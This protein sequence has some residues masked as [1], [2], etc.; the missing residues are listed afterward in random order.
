MAGTC[1][2]QLQ[3][4]RTAARGD[5]GT[6][7]PRSVTPHPP[8]CLCEDP[9]LNPTAHLRQRSPLVSLG[10]PERGRG[11]GRGGH[12][13]ADGKLPLHR[14]RAP[15]GLLSRPVL[16]TN[17]GVHSEGVSCAGFGGIGAV[18]SFWSSGLCQVAV[19]VLAL[20]A[21]PAGTRCELAAGLR[22]VAQRDCGKRAATS[23]DSRPGSGQRSCS[24]HGLSCQNFV[25]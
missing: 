5:S 4:R 3:E 24:G 2:E 13:G 10:G 18:H 7:C 8:S 14:P 9:W 20:F 22:A 21:S 11:A 19:W 23:S 15:T 25:I 17:P 16:E 12:G 1:R 6:S